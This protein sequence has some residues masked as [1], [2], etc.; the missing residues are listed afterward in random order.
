MIAG[1]LQ[2]GIHRVQAGLGL[3]LQIV[4]ALCQGFSLWFTL[5]NGAAPWDVMTGTA[6]R[7]RP[8][9]AARIVAFVL[10]FLVVLIGLSV[11]LK[12]VSDALL[13]DFLRELGPAPEGPTA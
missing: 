13:E 12:P 7:S 8:P 9:G 6:V 4:S 11:F 3:G 10:L 5:R 2:D 1:R